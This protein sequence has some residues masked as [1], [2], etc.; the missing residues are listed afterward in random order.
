[1]VKNISQRDKKGHQ[2]W[3]DNLKELK[4]TK[5]MSA[6][7]IA[8]KT[9]LPERTVNRIFS[10]DT[11]NPYVDTL[12]RI[13]TVLGGSLDDILADTKVVVATESL[14]E[15]KENA[16]VVEAERDLISAENAI[17]KDKVATLT[18]ENDMLK[19][20]IKHKEEIIALH[21]YYNKLLPNN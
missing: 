5:G 11:D 10:G 7:Q 21:N 18:A 9:N 20:E 14:V 19:R 13:V 8:D 16:N 2:M 12:H 1:M 3:L 15:V 17:L 4:K 6:K